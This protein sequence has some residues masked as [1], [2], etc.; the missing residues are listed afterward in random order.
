MCGTRLTKS[1]RNKGKKKK[2]KRNIYLREENRDQSKVSPGGIYGR[3]N[4]NG[5]DFNPDYFS[6][7]LSISF[8]QCS[9]GICYYIYD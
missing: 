6:I 3:Q 4:G 1:Q 7:P 9:M 2:V 5:T 8:Y